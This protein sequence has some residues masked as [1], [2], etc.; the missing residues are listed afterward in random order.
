M[1][2]SGNFL[3]FLS[4]HIFVP[5]HN[6]LKK[7]YSLKYVDEI[8]AFNKLPIE[9]IKRFQLERLRFIA[10]YAFKNTQYYGELFE[11]IGLRDPLHLNWDDYDRIPVLTKD[12]IRTEKDNLVS[13]LFRKADLRETA[14]G[15]TTS[16][17]M[18]FFSDWDSLY[19]KRSATTVFDNGLGI[20]LA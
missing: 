7:D 14:T 8:E 6:Y 3:D 4:L 17:P 9:N 20:N 15:G 10:D 1:N 11:K 2:S 16:S 13:R 12:I 19:R 18:P 5:L